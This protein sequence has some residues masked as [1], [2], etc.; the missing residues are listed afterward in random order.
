MSNGSKALPVRI[1]VGHKQ[2]RDFGV[3]LET[4]THK[5]LLDM[6][7]V[8]S[9]T[10]VLNPVPVLILNLKF[11]YCPALHENASLIAKILIVKSATLKKINTKIKT[12]HRCNWLMR[13]M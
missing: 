1:R 6:G 8:G 13:S 7:I 9:V 4:G 2:G 5:R 11:Q 3:C 10:S 12:A